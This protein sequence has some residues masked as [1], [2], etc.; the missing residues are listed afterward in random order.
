MKLH[1]REEKQ[2]DGREMDDTVLSP[3]IGNFRQVDVNKKV[4]FFLCFN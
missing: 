4:V 1:I 2:I 3:Q